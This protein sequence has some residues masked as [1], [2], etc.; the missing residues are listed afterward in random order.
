MLLIFSNIETL[1]L[2]FRIHQFVIII[3]LKIETKPKSRY[4]CNALY[5]LSWVV[6]TLIMN[7][8]VKTT[9]VC[10]IKTFLDYIICLFLLIPLVLP[11]D[12]MLRIKNNKPPKS[13]WYQQVFL[14]LVTLSSQFVADFEI[15]S[16]RPMFVGGILS[17]YT[18]Y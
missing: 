14:C 12:L 2:K 10:H 17:I 18:S 8:I 9:I 13:C 16:S 6:L 15:H 4:Y 1:R 7:P 11:N 5:T 3:F